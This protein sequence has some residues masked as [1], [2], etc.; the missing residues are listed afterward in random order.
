MSGQSSF[1]Q[2]AVHCTET[3]V[4]RV[5]DIKCTVAYSREF[6]RPVRRGYNP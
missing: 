5:Y 1:S 2:K 3:L 4:L 6:S